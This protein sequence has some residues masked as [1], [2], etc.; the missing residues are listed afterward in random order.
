[1]ISEFDYILIAAVIVESIVAA[2]SAFK[3][4][5][6][7]PENVSLQQAFDILESSVSSS[8]PNLPAGYTWKEV[9]SKIRLDY[10]EQE[11]IDWVDVEDRLKSYESIR[12]GGLRFETTNTGSIL[13]LA[14]LLR[15]REWLAR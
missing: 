11:G 15:K 2:L 6:K 12:Y 10:G 8:Y 13:K 4:G 7:L 3:R 9:I 1:M 5:S 14:R